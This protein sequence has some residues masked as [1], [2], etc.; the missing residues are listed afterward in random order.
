ML[1]TQ[2]RTRTRQLFRSTW[3][4][5]VNGEVLEPLEKQIAS[6]LDEHPEYHALVSGDD[7]V[8]DRNFVAEDGHENPFLHLSLHLALR[9]QVGTDR[10][11]GI[12]S[13]TRSLLLKHGDGHAVEHMM[14]EKLGLYLW[15]AQRQER[16]PDEAAYLNSLRE[17]L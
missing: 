10:P 11:V 6:L 15:E 1:F 14:I 17:L 5:H 13:I 2:D 4:K 3:H 7:D 9:E 12:A 16:A 8:L